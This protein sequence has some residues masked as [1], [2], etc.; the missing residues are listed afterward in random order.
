ME[1]RPLPRPRDPPRT[2]RSRFLQKSVWME[3]RALSLPVCDSQ[4]KPDAGPD[5]V[6]GAGPGRAFVPRSL[7]S[8]QRERRCASLPRQG[9]DA[10]PRTAFV[11]LID[12]ERGRGARDHPQSAVRGPATTLWLRPVFEVDAGPRTAFTVWGQEVG[13]RSSAFGAPVATRRARAG[14]PDWLYGNWRDLLGHP[15]S[16]IPAIQ[17]PSC[18][19]DL[20]GTSTSAKI[21]RLIW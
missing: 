1:G 17:D 12:Q 9:V 4:R 11:L 7:P 16:L 21:S 5:A 6:G 10:G 15:L 19:Q 14:R 2:G 8:T 20:P 18:P 3:G 13:E